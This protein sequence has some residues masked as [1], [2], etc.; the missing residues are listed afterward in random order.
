M[1]EYSIV[2]SLVERVE[3]EAAR[4][5]A[6]SVERIHVRVGALAGV[7]P[8]LLATAF[9]TFAP[10]SGCAGAALEIASAPGDELILERIEMEVPD[11]S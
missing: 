9:E 1:H 6:R 7:D 8:S 2:A 11:V 5:G 4:R 10:A 3:A